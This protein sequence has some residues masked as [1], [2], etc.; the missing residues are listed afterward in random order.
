MYTTAFVR[1]SL[2]CEKY[3]EFSMILTEPG[4]LDPDATAVQYT[5]PGPSL[6][7]TAIATSTE[8]LCEDAVTVRLV[9]DG[10]ARGMKT[11]PAGIVGCDDGLDN[12]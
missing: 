11:S 2:Y 6:P 7:L 5:V 1:A 10:T 12:G 4:A 8:A 3:G 9:M